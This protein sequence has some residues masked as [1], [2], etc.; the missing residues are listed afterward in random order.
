[1]LFDSNMVRRVDLDK[2]VTMLYYLYDGNEPNGFNKTTGDH[3]TILFINK[4]IDNVKVVGGVEGQYYPEKII[5]GKEMD[6]NIP[7]FSW[8]GPHKSKIGTLN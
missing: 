7:A 4:K 8:H 2:T 1:M 5:K 3:G 6:Y